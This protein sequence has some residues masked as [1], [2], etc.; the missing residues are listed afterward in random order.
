V[1]TISS[2]IV[3][4]ADLH[5]HILPAWDD[6][7]DV[8]EASL[9]MAA[10]AAD[11]G[12]RKILVTPHVGRALSAA[13][14][15]SPQEIPAAVARLQAQI[16]NAGIDIELVPGAEVLL[17]PELMVKRL[18]D[19]PWLSV[20]GRQR[21]ILVEFP[22]NEWPHWGDDIL[23]QISVQGITPILA[24][25]ER[26]HEVQ[27]DP[28]MIRGLVERGVALQ[29]TARSVVG[30]ERTSKTC[31]RQLLEAGLVS[32][33]ASDAHSPRHI[34]PTS[35]QVVQSLCDMIGDDAA[36][37]ILVDNPNR[38]LNGE[39]VMPATPAPSSRGAASGSSMT[40]RFFSFLKRA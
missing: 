21:Y 5:C 40:K 35:D 34:L 15:P 20:A 29:L 36:R 22:L 39:A 3:A 11:S 32:I 17:T 16:N 38:V 19:E 26:L 24:H 8:L 7:P 33:I 9:Q 18:S 12:L 23:F 31:S 25:P 13:Q 10:R 14:E 6:G 4:E 2:P 1:N 27:K 37:Q 28:T 30:A